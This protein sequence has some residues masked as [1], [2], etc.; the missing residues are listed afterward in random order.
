MDAEIPF[1]CCRGCCPAVCLTVKRISDLTNSLFRIFFIFHLSCTGNDWRNPSS[2]EGKNLQLLA[3]P[4]MRK[5]NEF[6]SRPSERWQSWS[7]E[8]S[9][10]KIEKGKLLLSR[11][12]T[13]MQSGSRTNFSGEGRREGIWVMNG[14]MIAFTSDHPKLKLNGKRR[15]GG[16][17]KFGGSRYF[18]VTPRFFPPLLLSC[19]CQA[20]RAKSLVLCVCLI[21]LLWLWRRRRRYR[22]AACTLRWVL[23]TVFFSAENRTGERLYKLGHSRF[24]Y[25][26]TFFLFLA[27]EEKRICLADLFDFL[28]S[29]PPPQLFSWPQAQKKGAFSPLL[30]TAAH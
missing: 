27:T 15:G 21:L 6:L 17:G 26:D 9:R 19:C 8:P 20:N 25:T 18:G 5:K 3:I 29:P 16:G 7:N 13:K 22:F 10:E 28:W 12:Q 23:P 4:H 24:D 1:C 11:I 14:I 30:L 2:G